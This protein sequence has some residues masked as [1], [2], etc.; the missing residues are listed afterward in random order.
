MYS[1]PTVG[2]CYAFA[3]INYTAATTICEECRIVTEGVVEATVA[4]NE[5]SAKAIS[6]DPLVD[7]A[8]SM[9][10]EV[11]FYMK[12]SNSSHA[13]SWQNLDG[14]TRGM[15]SVAYQASWNSLTNMWQGSLLGTSVST[16]YPVLIAQITNWRVYV[17][18][19][20]TGGLTISGLA[21]EIL[22]K[23][24]Q[25]KVIRNPAL[26]ALLLDTSAL[27]DQDTTGLCNSVSLRKKDGSLRL[28]LST[29][30]NDARYRDILDLRLMQTMMRV[31]LYRARNI[32]VVMRG[33]IRAVWPLQTERC[34]LCGPKMIVCGKV[35][36][37]S[38]GWQCQP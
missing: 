12:V 24:C 9:I 3:R 8:I 18:L 2:N 14:F 19:A 31:C 10:P 38:L 29:S 17:R 34:F 36:K 6:P 1:S 21:L 15:I 23:Q 13:P 37:R 25:H 32:V 7:N 16:P 35:N 20:L 4:A 28:R 26:A 27:L 5:S 30:N 11:L 33:G 22:Q